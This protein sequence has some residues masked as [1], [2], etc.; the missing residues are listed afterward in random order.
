MKYTLLINHGEYAKGLYDTEQEVIVDIVSRIKADE[1][2]VPEGM[3][4]A[5]VMDNFDDGYYRALEIKVEG[6]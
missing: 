5:D 2:E 1:P 6:E 3:S 4:D